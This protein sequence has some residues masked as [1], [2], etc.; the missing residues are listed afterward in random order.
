MIIFGQKLVLE[1]LKRIDVLQEDNR[2]LTDAILRDAGKPVIFQ[3]PEM[4]PSTSW[5]DAA[6]KIKVAAK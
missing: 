3:K 5:F 4:K 1:L 6:P 2:R